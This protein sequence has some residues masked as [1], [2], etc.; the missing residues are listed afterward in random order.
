MNF[1]KCK[2]LLALPLALLFI[3]PIDALGSD[4]PLDHWA[5]DYLDRLKVKGLLDE[6]L[7]Q[8]RPIS[9]KEVALAVWQVTEA[10]QAGD[11]R[12]T[13]VERS[14]L[15]WLQMEFAEELQSHSLPDKGH[16]RHLFRWSDGHRGLILDA[17]GMGRGSLGRD[18][19]R[20]RRILDFRVT[21][22][23]RGFLGR[24]LSY[25]ASVVK[26]QVNSNLDRVVKEDVGLTGYFDSR[27]SYAYYDWSHA[28]LTLRVPWLELQLGRQPLSWGPGD[29]GH[30]ALSSHPPAYDFVQI[31]VTVRRVRYVYLHG[32]LLSGEATER[33]TPEGFI[34][35]EYPNKF[36]AAHRIEASPFS[37]LSLGL[38][39]AIIYG[40]RGLDLAYLNP[41][42]LFW[43][44]QHSSHDRDN[45]ILG[46]DFRARPIKGF[47]LYGALFIDEL[48]LEDMFTQDARN[49]VALQ[50][51]LY[52]V[53]LLGFE[54]TD[55][56]LEYTRVQPCVYTHKFPVND[57]C[58][59]GV[60]LGHWLEE[61][62]DDL[63]LAARH[64]F[65]RQL[66][67]VAHLGR[68]RRGEKGEQPWCHLD[69]GRYSFLW[70]TVDRTLLLGLSLDV[71]PSHNLRASM[72]YERTERKNRDHIPGEDENL[73]ELSFTLSF[74]Y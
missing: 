30:L 5:Y 56:R 48:S 20:N 2:V 59:D 41:L 7:N 39:E 73:D 18:H 58:H 12:I 53:D 29:R 63:Y 72:S 33:V 50:G 6:F 62:G 52:L 14:Q 67:I 40:E 51:G 32:F 16:E 71:E 13:E 11:S 21:L 37:W 10:A 4:L 36:V 8:T 38:H 34:R 47:S 19:G 23:A 57:Y 74:D 44:A 66:S 35:K 26:G 17:V 70:G 28:H 69:S 54:N 60:T 65:S 24:E 46:G 61:N 64:R 3:V 25:A 27:G 15:E 68:T 22:Q 31:R 45:V 43:S 1:G 49:K 42:V 55:F 9:R